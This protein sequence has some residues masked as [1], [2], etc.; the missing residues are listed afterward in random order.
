[1]T[2]D[3]LSFELTNS[4]RRIAHAANR[5]FGNMAG[6]RIYSQLFVRY[7]ASVPADGILMSI[8]INNELL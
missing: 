1:M 7:S 3:S 8:R 5:R 4:E 2:E 6:R